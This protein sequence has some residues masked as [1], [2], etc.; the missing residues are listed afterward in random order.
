MSAIFQLP[1]IVEDANHYYFGE[2]ETSDLTLRVGLD[3]ERYFHVHW[4][5]VTEASEFFKTMRSSGLREACEDVGSFSEDSP[6]AWK[7]VLTCL[8]CSTTPKNTAALISPQPMEA[9]DVILIAPLVHR[10][11]I[12]YLL[13]K[14]K[15]AVK[16]SSSTERRTPEIPD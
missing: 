3:E 6:E 9:V 14:M 5:V 8:Y 4:K 7:I 1:S 10:L 13:N 12:P 15:A 11:E 2:R 16:F